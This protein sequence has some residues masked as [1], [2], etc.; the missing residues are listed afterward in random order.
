V[1]ADGTLKWKFAVP[2]GVEGTPALGWDGTIYF[3]SYDSCL[4]ALRDLG[5]HADLLWKF[6]T[7]GPIDACPTVDGD[8]TIYIGS[9]DGV[10]Y[11]VNPDG[12]EKWRYVTGGGIESSVTIDDNG[13]MYFGSFDGKLYCLGTGT[14]DVGVRAVVLADTVIP[15]Q[16]Y[17]PA[18][19]LA[20]YR[21][22][23]VDFE[24]VCEIDSAGVAVY[25]DSISVVGLPGGSSGQFVF[26]GW[27][28]GPSTGVTYR[29]R[30]WTV[31]AGDD[32]LPNDSSEQEVI[33]AAGGC[34]VGP[35]VGNI[36]GSA[37]D[38]V[39]MGD[40]TVLIDYL[41]ISFTEPECIAEANVDLS[42]DGLVTMGDLTVLIDHLFIS[43]NPLPPCP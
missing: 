22:Q 27:T 19:T 28:P 14:P 7:G 16:S 13:F 36:D 37:D 34:C 9:R 30:V 10:M 38:Q 18:A 33:T 43:F 2:I 39:T 4:Y 35:M 32:N 25:G 6:P 42:A 17:A 23:P 5:T 40:L 29:V 1:N 11:A 12:S 21:G 31:L 3:G 26:A 41:F 20:N 15:G 8:G 24:A